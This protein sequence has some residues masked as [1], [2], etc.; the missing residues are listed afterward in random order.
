[1]V[2][3]LLSADVPNR[4]DVPRVE[5][6]LLALGQN[7]IADTAVEPDPIAGCRRKVDIDGN[8]RRASHAGDDSYSWVSRPKV[9]VTSVLGATESTS[10]QSP[11][12]DAVYKLL[13]RAMAADLVGPKL[14]YNIPT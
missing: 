1:M 14:H 9:D 3:A 4:Y 2:K 11:S 8:I 6:I 13:V 5:S 10:K 12:Q 7:Y